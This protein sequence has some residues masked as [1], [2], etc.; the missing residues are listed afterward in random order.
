MLYVSADWLPGLCW[1]AKHLASTPDQSTLGCVTIGDTLN[2]DTQ[3][4]Y[5]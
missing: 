5:L 1:Q 3:R 4:A 2:Q